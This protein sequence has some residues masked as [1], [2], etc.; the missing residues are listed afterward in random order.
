MKA[1]IFAGGVGTRLWPLSRKKSPKQFEKIIGEKSTLQLAVDRLLEGINPEDIYISTGEAYF[2]IVSKQLDSIPKENVIAEPMKRDVGP[3]VAVVMGFLAKKFP[4]EPVLILWSDHLV[5]E[6]EKF[7]D[8]VKSAGKVIKEDPKKIIFI[9]QKPRFPSENLGWIESGE[10]LIESKHKFKEFKGFKY[11]PDNVLAKKYFDD[12]NKYCWNLGYFV[13]TPTFLYD[14]YGRFSPK[15]HRVAEKIL[16]KL[17]PKE[18]RENLAK[19]YG[20][21]PEISFDNAV[22]E[23]LDNSAAYVVV[24]DIGWSDVGAW[25]ALKEALE[26][27]RVDNITKGEVLLEDAEDCL[28]YNYENKKLVVGI[29]LKDHLVINTDDV[30]LV[31]KKSSVAKIKPLLKKFE[32]T[33]YEKLT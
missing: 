28:V 15:I 18:F 33:S 22:L 9:G 17:T 11:K 29:D 1:V 25:E 2:D 26:E 10:S 23:Q 21:M 3:A 27:K 5:K 4:N 7:L 16:K 12:P 20:E 13:T 30:L 24:D 6:E 8:I 31:G 19:F 32:G 14:L